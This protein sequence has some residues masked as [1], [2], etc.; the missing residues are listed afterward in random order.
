[1][2][3]PLKTVA[4]VGLGIGRSHLLEGYANHPDKFRVL[5]VCDLAQDRL[6]AVGDEFGVPRRTTSY[7]EVLGM[8]DID[9]VD[10]C[11]P[12]MVHKGQILAALAAGKDVICEKPLVGSLADVE[13]VAAAEKAS[14]GAVMPIFQYRWGDGFQRALHVVRAGLAGTPYLATAETHW[15]RTADY[16]AVPWRGKFATELGGVLLTH[17]IHLHDMACELMGPVAELYCRTATRVNPIEVED[18]AAAT[19][20]LESGAV[21]SLS[22][23]LGAQNEISRLRCC[24]EHVTFESGLEPYAPGNEPWQIIPSSTQAA[25][26]IEEALATFRPVHPRFRGQLE[27]YHAALVGGGPLPVTLADARRSL[28]LITALYHSAATRQPVRLPL[29]PDHPRFASW[30]P[31]A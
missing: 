8:A 3:A 20:A 24:F 10:I 31:A 28:E 1:M 11:T 18:C 2:T 30:R 19:L 9:I 21:M 25:A 12:P 14:R 4:V 6:A 17:A 26:R 13:E 29:Q 7:D 16:Y 22:A 15:K 23:T 27:A 5:A